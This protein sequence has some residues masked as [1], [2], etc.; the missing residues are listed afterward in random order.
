MKELF[1]NLCRF[2]KRLSGRTQNHSQLLE[3]IYMV[4]ERRASSFLQSISIVFDIL[5]VSVFLSTSCN[6][7]F[8]SAVL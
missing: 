6:Y 2:L 7:I 8:I 3:E 4:Y 5:H 1:S